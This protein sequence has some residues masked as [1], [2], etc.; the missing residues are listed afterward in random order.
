MHYSF[1]VVKRKYKIYKNAVGFWLGSCSVNFWKEV[2][3]SF[4]LLPFES[5]YYRNVAYK[6]WN[7]CCSQNEQN[8]AYVRILLLTLCA[9][10]VFVTICFL[11]DKFECILYGYDRY[12]KSTNE[13]FVVIK[14]E[15]NNNAFVA[16]QIWLINV[17]AFTFYVRIIWY[18]NVLE[19]VV[20]LQTQISKIT[21]SLLWWHQ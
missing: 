2:P 16:Y 19:H 12:C 9:D 6:T 18:K 21:K 4:C 20:W 11:N 17:N 3:W 14:A 5:F 10:Q 7:F 15:T 8:Y 1:F 13:K